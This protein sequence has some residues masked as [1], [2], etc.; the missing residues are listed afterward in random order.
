M[1]IKQKREAVLEKVYDELLDSDLEE[2]KTEARSGF[3]TDTRKSQNQLVQL[4]VALEDAEAKD[5]ELAVKSEELTF[6]NANHEIDVEHED[7]SE[8]I[9]L[10]VTSGITILTNVVWGMI[11][12]H[13]LNATREFER[14]GTETSAA[15]RWLKQSFPKF[16]RL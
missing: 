6:E 9:K 12:I 4:V 10:L 1:G 8:L 7:R 11:F 3:G 14:D 5:G 15:G 13:E 16:G 2:F